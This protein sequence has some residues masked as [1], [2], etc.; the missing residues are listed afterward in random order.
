MK[1]GVGEGGESPP[2]SSDGRLAWL[3]WTRDEN[4][5]RLPLGGGAPKRLLF[6][7]RRDND[8]HISPDGRT[9]TFASDRSGSEQV[10]IAN[11]DGSDDRPVTA[12]KGSMTGGGRFSPD[13]R[14]I[15]FVSSKPGQ[16]EVYRTTPEGRTP[17]RVT[18]DPG[19]DCGASFSRD[20]RFTYFASNRDGRFQVWKVPSDGGGAPVRVT[21][22]GGFAALESADGKTLYY[23]KRIE[24]AT[25]SV[26]RMPADGG[27][28]ELVLPLIATWGDFD[29]TPDGIA[30]IDAPSAGARLALHP[31]G[32]GAEKVLHTMEK[33]TSFGVAVSRD[34][35]WLLFSQYDQESTEILTVDRFR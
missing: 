27:D 11:A 14:R 35:S 21:R 25:W 30:F 24:R 10:W 15:V 20:G 33:R 28:E 7:T 31:F 12:M 8:P 5:W 29:V 23:A 18:N 6:S 13:G 26:W 32:G 9:I 17:V 2:I 19:H 34:A 16:M 1:P 22:N 4:V 3:R